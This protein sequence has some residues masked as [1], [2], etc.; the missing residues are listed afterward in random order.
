MASPFAAPDATH[1]DAAPK[2]APTPSFPPST[3]KPTSYLPMGLILGG[4]GLVLLFGLIA[5]IV[6]CVIHVRRTN[7][8]IYAVKTS[9]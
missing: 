2:I 6:T 1:P 4:L 9:F 3:T 8:V 7:H 5:G